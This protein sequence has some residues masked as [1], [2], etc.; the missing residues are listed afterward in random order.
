MKITK[1]KRRIKRIRRVEVSGGGDDKQKELHC[2]FFSFKIFYEKEAV[3]QHQQ[4]QQKIINT[5]IN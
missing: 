1:T 3:Q 4:P 5:F 2:N